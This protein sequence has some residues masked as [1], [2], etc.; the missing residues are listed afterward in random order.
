MRV[1]VFL[2]FTLTS[3]FADD[4]NRFSYEELTTLSGKTYERVTIRKVE[5]DGLRIMH[6][7]GMAK[8]SFEDLPEEVRKEH[9][10][11]EEEAAA[12]R[13][14]QE[15][16]ERKARADLRSDEARR[17]L[18][19]AN[20]ELLETVKNSAIVAKGKVIQNPGTGYVRASFNQKIIQTEMVV[21]GLSRKPKKKVI[22]GGG[23]SNAI[24]YGLGN[25]VDGESW[26]SVLYPAGT[27]TYETVLGAGTTV[28]RYA[29]TPER[30]IQLLSR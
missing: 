1:M 5:P 14:Q 30:A 24:I 12:Y 20:R 18:K 2:I 3:S 19:K 6:S 25:P 11:S 26:E 10:Y 13:K 8:I 17:R 7:S 21:S 29:T 15:E 23:D 9:G 4:E 16:A 28:K 27:M 22:W